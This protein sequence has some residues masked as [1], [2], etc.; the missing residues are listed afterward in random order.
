M[1]SPREDRHDEELVLIQRARPLWPPLEVRPVGPDEVDVVGVPGLLLLGDAGV[2]D[3]GEAPGRFTEVAAAAVADRDEPVTA[4]PL[5]RAPDGPPQ[6]G[7]GGR[8]SQPLDIII[9]G[10][11]EGGSRKKQVPPLVREATVGDVPAAPP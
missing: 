6:E 8:P 11:R 3:A 5:P 7:V 10:R 1:V 4:C 2:L 9:T